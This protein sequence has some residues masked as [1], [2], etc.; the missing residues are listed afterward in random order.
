MASKLGSL[1]CSVNGLPLAAG[2][3]K[4][5]WLRS[6]LT[7]MPTAKTH[8]HGLLRVCRCLACVVIRPT[9]QHCFR[10]QRHCVDPVCVPLERPYQLP[11]CCAPHVYAAVPA[12]AVDKPLAAPAHAGHNHGVAA[13]SEK[14]AAGVGVPDAHGLVFAAT[15]EAPTGQRLVG[16]LPGL[17]MH[18][19]TTQSRARSHKANLRSPHPYQTYPNMRRHAFWSLLAPAHTSRHKQTHN[20]TKADTSPHTAADHLLHT[21]AC[22]LQVSRTTVVLVS[23]EAPTRDV[24]HLLCPL[25][26][27]KGLPVAGSHSHI[28]PS[29]SP[30]ATM[31]P[32]GD[33]ATHSTQ[34]L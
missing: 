22:S 8:L 26:V 23:A 20:Y 31:A 30:L 14:A 24:I 21:Q 16:W 6:D 12:A 13:H 5:A 15:H 28:L 18:Q 4:V 1:V 32:S 27:L 3:E 10:A 29:M 33:Q 2:Q 17:N 11:F 7:A 19:D 9:P 25:Q 34:F